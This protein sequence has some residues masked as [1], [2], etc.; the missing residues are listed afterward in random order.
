M[1][2]PKG[3][4]QIFINHR[5]GD[6]ERGGGAEGDESVEVEDIDDAG[7]HALELPSS[8]ERKKT[9]NK[10]IKQNIFIY[11]YEKTLL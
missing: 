2:M 11:K 9:L 4:K 10:S 5:H 3:S 1:A 7:S 8:T 6:G